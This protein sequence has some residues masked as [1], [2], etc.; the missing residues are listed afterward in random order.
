M[1]P[2]ELLQDALDETGVDLNMAKDAALQLVAAEGARLT[3][4]SQE[5]GFNLVLRASRQRIA[6][7]LGIDASQEA[8]AV[9]GRIVGILQS[10]LLGLA[11]A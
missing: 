2:L 10:V 5:P 7:E 6:L 11:T 1:N 8:R 3:L 4:A 9:D